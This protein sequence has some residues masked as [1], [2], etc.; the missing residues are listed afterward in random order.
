MAQRLAGIS[1][2]PGSAA[3][4]LL[5]SPGGSLLDGIGIGRAISA[6]P[7]PVTTDV[8]SGERA[9]DCASACVFAYMGGRSCTLREGSRLGV[10]QFYPTDGGGGMTGAEGM[11]VG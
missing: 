5:A 6:L 11:A 9:A 10:H 3:R 2:P 8:G 1:F 4:V 7:V